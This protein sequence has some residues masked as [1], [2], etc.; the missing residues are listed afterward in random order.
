MA[1]AR[2]GMLFAN[3]EIIHFMNT[4]KM[5]YNIT[6]HTIQLGLEAIRNLSKKQAFIIELLNEKRY[7]NTELNKISKKKKSLILR[8]LILFYLK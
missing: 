4:I 5:P 7:L 6:Q 1:D 8:I 2:L 3:S